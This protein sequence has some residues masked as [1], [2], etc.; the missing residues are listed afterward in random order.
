MKNTTNT[1]QKVKKLTIIAL[2]CANVKY[3][4]TFVHESDILPM[5]IENCESIEV[6][7]T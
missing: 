2:F 4:L 3:M 5:S 6:R 1:S 7:C